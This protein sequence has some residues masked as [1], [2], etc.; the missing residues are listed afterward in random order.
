MASESLSRTLRGGYAQFERVVKLDTPAGP[1]RLVPL[2]VKG[3]ARLGRDY[4]FVVEAAALLDGGDIDARAILGSAVTLWIRQT[5]RSYMPIHGYVHHF[6]EL[7]ADGSCAYYQLRFSSWLYFLRLRRDQRDWQETTGEQILIDVFR[8]HP[9]AT[10]HNAYRFDL[11]EPMPAYSY[12]MQWETDLNFVY[13]SM[14]EAGVFGRF[15][16]AEDGRSH[17]FVVTDSVSQVPVLKQSVVQLSHAGDNEE[18]D[19]FVSFRERMQ[20][21]SARLTANTFDYKQPSADKRIECATASPD[22]LPVDGEVYDYTGA[23][24]WGADSDGERYVRNRIEAW[25]SQIQR[26]DAVGGLRA[27]MPGYRFT[28]SRGAALD[29]GQSGDNEYVILGVDWMIR[30]NVPGLDAY[31]SLEDSLRDELAAR[32]AG[33]AG[34]AGGDV[35]GSQGF[36]QVKVELQRR[37]TP[38]RLPREHRKPTMSL[39]NAVV[40][41]PNG[42]E[43]LTDRLN[44]A[45]LHFPW[46][47]DAQA[48]CWVR[49]AFADAGSQRG[50]VHP[51][52]DGDE[53]LVDFVGGDCDRPVV[54]SRVFGGDT[55][56]VWHSDGLLSG[57]RSKE[58]SGSG[59][60]QLALDDSTGQ[61]RVQLYSSS[62]QTHLHLG[63]LIQHE[64]N[65]RGAFLGRGFDLKSDAY[66]ALRAGQGLFVSTHP[67]TTAQPL[68]VAPAADQLAGA[69]QVADLASQ[70]S[71]ANRAE[72]LDDG[73]HALDRFTQATHY[74]N[75]GSVAGG[76]TA[77]GGQGSANG[78]AMPVMLLAS[79]A[80]MGLSTQDSLQAT[81]SQHVNVVSGQSTHVAAGKSFLVSAMEKLSLFVQNAGMKLFAA[82]GKVE[83]Q[84]Q[85][86]AM[87]LSALKDLTITSASGR[88]VLSA[89]KE[90]WIGAGG[91]YIKITPDLIENGTTGQ[92]LEKCASWDKPGAASMR[93]PA[94]LPSAAKSCAWRMGGAAADS[95]S[96]VELG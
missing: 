50:A 89:D 18:F 70:A 29:S 52:R 83:I 77:G 45:R 4:E 76:R 20:L 13:R 21:Q 42:E 37:S 80:G 87:A 41:A 60:N 28:L 30:N 34:S 26:F 47:R 59:Y 88:L 94:E 48:C 85:S 7:G 96:S 65:S 17:T 24:T 62:Y 51:L 49:T 8:A 14:E 46:Y 79:P 78:F 57:Y 16:F 23:Y 3:T 92:I 53:V 74:S 12:R 6:A 90:I 91:S 67:T 19:G 55:Q 81:A 93:L 11:N 61:N 84:A 36:F 22:G 15:E 54:V 82:K 25:E 86:D 40:T 73:L 44:R 64:N 71:A 56:P 68:D 5:D 72:G 9:Q 39:M 63:Y 35:D 10:T 66:G 2:W 1:D 58:Y 95:A 27:A 31:P 75:A 38:F 32:A 43:V 69:R 33:R